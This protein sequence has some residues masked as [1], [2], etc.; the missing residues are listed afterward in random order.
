LIPRRK[1]RYIATCSGKRGFGIR[2]KAQAM[3]AGKMG[4]HCNVVDD[5][6]R[7]ETD[8]PAIGLILCQQPNRV[9]AEYALRVVG[10]PT[11]VAGFALDQKDQTRLI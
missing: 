4:F 10:N 3:Y 5:Q 2:D 11:G 1:H 6:L 7:H 9:L 8:K